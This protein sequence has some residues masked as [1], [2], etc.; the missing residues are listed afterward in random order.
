MATS[1]HTKHTVLCLACG[2]VT[3]RPSDRWRMKSSTSQHVVP[4]RKHIVSRELEKRNQQADL[5]Q[6]ISGYGNPEEVG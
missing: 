3:Q 6:I 2:E 1:G 5:D 4:L